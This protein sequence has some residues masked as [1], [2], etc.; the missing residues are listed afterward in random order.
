M[1]VVGFNTSTLKKS[2]GSFPEFFLL[3]EGELSAIFSCSRYNLDIFDDLD[4][5]VP[6]LPPPLPS[7]VQLNC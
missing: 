4:E 7:L 6:P 2:G 3:P 1:G 5:S